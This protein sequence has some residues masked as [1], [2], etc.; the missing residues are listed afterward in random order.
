MEAG[1]APLFAGSPVLSL[2][3]RFCYFGGNDDGGE[4]NPRRALWAPVTFV[5]AVP[6]P[7]S[8]GDGRGSAVAAGSERRAGVRRGA[9]D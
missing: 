3:R 9:G 8:P 5:S 2:K 1:G 7:G 4:T 6:R